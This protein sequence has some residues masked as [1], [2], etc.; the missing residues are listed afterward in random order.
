M[1]GCQCLE[2]LYRQRQCL[3]KLSL[4]L[5]NLSVWPDLGVQAASVFSSISA[6]CPSV[7]LLPL[8]F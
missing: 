7:Q 6:R 5:E 1:A 3:A 2:L 4:N 8:R